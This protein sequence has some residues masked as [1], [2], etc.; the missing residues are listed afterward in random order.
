MKNT[1]A[2]K[3]RNFLAGIA[4]GATFLAVSPLATAKPG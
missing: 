1:R 4:T 3:R 2:I